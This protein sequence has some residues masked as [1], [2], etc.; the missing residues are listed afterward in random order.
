MSSED[1]QAELCSKYERKVDYLNHSSLEDLICD[2]KI[3][4]KCIIVDYLG[5]TDNYFC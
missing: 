4:L 2:H 1:E 5:E 3:C